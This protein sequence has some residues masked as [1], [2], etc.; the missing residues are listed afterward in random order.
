MPAGPLAWPL[1]LV[2]AAAWVGAAGMLFFIGARAVA[3]DSNLLF[4]WWNAY[5]WWVYIPA[6][7]IA[8]AAVVLRKRWLLAASAVVIVFHLLWILPDY[9]PAE[10][11]PDEAHSAPTLRLMTVNVFFENEDFGPLTAEI[12]AVDA[13][14]VFIQEYGPGI[15]SALFEGGAAEK[16]PYRYIAMENQYFG[17]ATYSKLPLIGVEA[18]EAGGRPFIRATV[19]VSGIP[20][21]LYNV[22]PTSPGLGEG[23]AESW[24]DGWRDITNALVEETGAAVVAGDFNM[25]QHHR[26][27]RQLKSDGMKSCHEERGRGN[28][29]TWPQMRRLP[30]IRLDN[31]FHSSQVVCMS[32]REGDG[33]GSDHKPVV[34]E[35]A[36]L[37]R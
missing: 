25:N 31:I 30:P 36:I 1:R 11:I 14:V 17:L 2:A 33:E 6:Y 16:Y 37:P 13:D 10:D 32:V 18:P 29:T 20:V 15:E 19:D 23:F 28:A 26:W 24:N 8:V 5:T 35:L 34:A 12:L 27:Y 22:H 7:F 4:I 9:R 3:P 21:R